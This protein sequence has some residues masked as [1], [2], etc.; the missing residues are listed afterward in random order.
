MIFRDPP[1][2]SQMIRRMGNHAHGH[3]GAK[4]F[5]PI[6]YG[7][8]TA[9]GVFVTFPYARL[10]GLP[11]GFVDGFYQPTVFP[12]D[13]FGTAVDELAHAVEIEFCVLGLSSDG[14]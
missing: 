4:A 3:A 10:Q 7:R 1:N 6:L 5:I 13:V 9:E 14:R 2:R 12:I 8:K 11:L